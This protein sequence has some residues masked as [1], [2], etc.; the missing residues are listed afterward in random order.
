MMREFI[1]NL[2]TICG[3]FGL[4]LF[5]VMVMSEILKKPEWE[6]WR[7][8]VTNVWVV[9]YFLVIIAEKIVL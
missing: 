3:Y 2:S 8:K 1:I 5:I 6:V 4:P 9:I 7:K